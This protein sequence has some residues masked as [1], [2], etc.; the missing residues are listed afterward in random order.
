MQIYVH[1]VS[2]IQAGSPVPLYCSRR[3]NNYNYEQFNRKPFLQVV[4]TV[5]I[6]AH[7]YHRYRQAATFLYF[8]RRIN[9]Y[10]KCIFLDLFHTIRICLPSF[11]HG[12]KIWSWCTLT[13]MRLYDS[14]VLQ[15]PTLFIRAQ[16]TCRLPLSLL[17]VLMSLP[18]PG[19]RYCSFN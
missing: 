18:I 3:N 14:F 9:Y 15:V 19:S 2:Q 17:H 13:Y 1:R 6:Y 7:A 5:Q 8:S 10:Y 16:C 12:I 11:H 4:F